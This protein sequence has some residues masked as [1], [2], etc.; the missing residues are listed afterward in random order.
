MEKI[1]NSE[2]I[3]KILFEQH[4]MNHALLNWIVN[5]NVH[6]NLPPFYE[7]ILRHIEKIDDLYEEAGF[8]YIQR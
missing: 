7:E 5:E 3:T 8:L 2:Q 1:V 6:G 4:K